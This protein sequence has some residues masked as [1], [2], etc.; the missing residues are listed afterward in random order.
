MPIGLNR[1]LNFFNRGLAIACLNINS[2]TAH[3]DELRVFMRDSKIDV[4]AI[5]ESKLDNTIKDREVYLPGYEIV[6]RDRQIN[7]RQGGGVGFYLRS[8][9]NFK[10][11]KELMTE[12]LECLTVEINKP[13][14][15]PFLVSTWYRPPNSPP[16]LFDDFENLIGKI[17]G[18]NRELYLVGDMNTNL[19]PG[20]ADS[21]S[22]KLINVCEIFGLSQLITEPTRVTALS[23]SLIDLCIT[24]T[25]DK[26]VRSGVMPLGI[27]RISDHSL[28][29]LIRKTHFT[30]PGCIKIINTRSFKNFNQEEFLAATF[31]VLLQRSQKC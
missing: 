20:V 8:N 18:S 3:I 19:L 15:R 23:Q 25:P 5:N 9:L 12:R 13:H 2:L 17:D 6:R 30:I 22:S 21:N 29:Y 16:D 26:I 14:S 31:I 27:S 1:K 4:L 7:G 11:C 10:V 24:N 28:V